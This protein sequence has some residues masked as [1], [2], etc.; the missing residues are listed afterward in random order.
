M[1]NLGPASYPRLNSLFRIANAYNGVN[2]K[3]KY[4][5]RNQGGLA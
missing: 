5:M 2:G 1:G 3:N 4:L